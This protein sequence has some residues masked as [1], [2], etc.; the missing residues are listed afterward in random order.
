[1]IVNH[2]VAAA[3]IAMTLVTNTAL[4]TAMSRRSDMTFVS[5][6]R[7]VIAIPVIGSG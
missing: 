6:V 2:H 3:V 5:G 7:G 1:M 4:V